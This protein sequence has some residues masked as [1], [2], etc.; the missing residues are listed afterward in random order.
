[1]LQREVPPGITAYQP[2][3]CLQASAGVKGLKKREPQLQTLYIVQ[4]RPQKSLGAIR[5]L[6]SE[7][8]TQFPTLFNLQNLC[9]FPIQLGI[10]LFIFKDFNCFIH[11]ISFTIYCFCNGHFRDELQHSSSLELTNSQLGCTQ[12]PAFPV[13]LQNFQI[14]NVF[15]DTEAV[16]KKKF[17]SCPAGG[18]NMGHPGDRDFFLF[19]FFFFFPVII[20]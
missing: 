15:P 8:T 2:R 10:S 12:F 3:E 4:Q 9:A 11:E 19:L 14:C 6:R 16:H 13:F 1:M 7:E 20:Q 18:E 5:E 17:V